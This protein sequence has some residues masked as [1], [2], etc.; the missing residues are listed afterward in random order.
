MKESRT[1]TDARGCL[2]EAEAALET[3]P[4]LTR[5]AEGLE[6][7]DDLLVTGSQAE[8]RTAR[9]LASTYADRIY[10]R[11][12]AVLAAHP[13]LPEPRLEHL[14]KVALAFDRINVA[15]PPTATE[16]KVAVVRALVD[17]YYEGHPE[18]R[19]RQIIEQLAALRT[20]RS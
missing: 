10:A 8:A 18:E 12:G 5:L 9:N 3:A 17:R 4:G 16:L 6:L 2:A 14:F 15:L 7:L 1:L 19:K 20:Q 11:I 13:Q